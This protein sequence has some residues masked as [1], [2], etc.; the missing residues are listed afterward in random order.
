MLRAVIDRTDCRTLEVAVGLVTVLTGL[1]LWH[2]LDTFGST[3]AFQA[4][5]PAG[6]YPAGLVLA[7]L[8]GLVIW[9]PRQ[10]RTPF[11]WLV[12]FLWWLIGFLFFF[13]NAAGTGWLW[14]HCFA[15]AAAL[16]SCLVRREGRGDRG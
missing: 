6:D 1:W 3:V 16:W 5:R 8:G 15:A 14:A 7:V 4:F 13:G 9:G 12:G 10:A 2:P 11:L